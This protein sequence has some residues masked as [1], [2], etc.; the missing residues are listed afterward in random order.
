MPSRADD[1]SWRS[2]GYAWW[3]V[4]VLALGL[5]LSLMDR[6]IIALMIGPIKR[7]LALSDTDIGLLQGLAFTLLYV[8]AGLPTAALGVPAAAAS[9]AAARRR[10]G[11]LIAIPAG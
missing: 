11:A 5:T 1:W 7:D 9:L 4:V 3:V 6:L 10:H 8:I 2:P